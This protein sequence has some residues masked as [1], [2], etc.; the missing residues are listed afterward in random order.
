MATNPSRRK[1]PGKI[2]GGKPGPGRPRGV[3]KVFDTLTVNERRE[4]AEKGGVTPVQFLYSIMLDPA[5]LLE[6]RVDAAK[7]C[8]PYFHRKMPQAIEL[9]PAL[10][11]AIE[12]AKLLALPKADREALLELL[13]R[14]GIDL[15]APPGAPGADLVERVPDGRAPD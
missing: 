4:L 15:T 10:T 9:P 2:G 6:V 11:P 12:M 1:A 7:A 3:F 5:R 14:I 8:A 13:Q